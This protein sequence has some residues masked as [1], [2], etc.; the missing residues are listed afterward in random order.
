VGV[1]TEGVV[2]VCYISIDLYKQCYARII[3]QEEPISVID[4]AKQLG[5]YKQTIFKIIK[6]LKIATIKQ[7]HS[8]HRGQAISYITPEDLNRLA[9]YFHNNKNSLNEVTIRYSNEIDL[10]DNGVFYLIQLEPN[11]DPGRFKVGF[12]TIM[13]ERLRKHR[14]AAPFSTVIETWPC[15]RLWEQTAIDCV[16][17]GCEKIH[18]EVFKTNAIESVKNKC[19]HFFSLMPK[20]E[21][22]K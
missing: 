21:K 8:E 1:Y 5:Q 19:E 16:T 22:N 18:T 12:A 6:K 11:H 2:G 10:S 9:T 13:D 3:M 15:R 20:N 14:C 7:R 4:A 17:A